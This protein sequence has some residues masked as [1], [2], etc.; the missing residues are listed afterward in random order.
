MRLS[1]LSMA[2]VLALGSQAA[3]H[4]ALSSGPAA[5]NKSQKITFGVGH[6]CEIAGVE[7]DT[8]RIRIDIPEGVTS[9]RALRSEFGKP[10]LIKEAGTGK[11]LAVEWQK[12]VADLQPE[13]FGY[14]E[15]TLRAKIAD[16]PFTQIKW[17]IHQTC[18]TTAGVETTVS[19]NEAPGGTGS[20]SPMMTV[21]P[22]RTPGWNKYVLPAAIP[23]ARVPMFFADALI[24]WRG[25]AA[26]SSNPN[27][28][29]TITSTP[30]VTALTGDLAAGDEI[31]VRY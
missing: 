29:A 7:T 8:Y 31:W 30:G 21:V 3:A 9:V 4:V 20:P 10:K 17:D 6:G 27:T 23:E 15:I 14:Y 24:A 18:R 12:P 16:V 26:Y 13:D 28:A 25:T 11:L 1:I 2:F 19:W 22:A 5:A